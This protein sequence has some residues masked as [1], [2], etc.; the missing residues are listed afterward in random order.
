LAWI[1]SRSLIYRERMRR[2]AFSIVLAASSLACP[3]D[4]GGRTDS[5]TFSTFN[6]TGDGDGDGDGGE[7]GT[8]NTGDGDGDGDGGAM[9]G[10][11]VIE[12]GEQ[13]DLGA[14]N[15]NDGGCTTAC[16]IASCGDG[17]VYGGVEECDDGNPVETDDC[18]SN[19]L[20]ASCGDGYVHEGVEACDDGN[21]VED[22][23]CTTTCVTGI[24]GDAILQPGEQCDDGNLETSDACPACEL[25]YCGDGYTQAGVEFC[26]DGNDLDNDACLPTFCVEASCGDGFMQEGV[27]ACDDGND[28]ENDDCT[29]A[30][31]AA[32]C[33]DG[34][35]Q[36][37]EIC[38]GDQFGV[39]SCMT[40]GFNN[41]DLICTVDCEIDASD[42]NNTACP[43]GGAFVSNRCWYASSVCET[44]PV[45]CQSVGLTGADG[46]INTPWNQQVLD[47]VAAQLGLISGGVNGCCVEFG[48]I[49]NG[50]LY[51]HNFGV[52]FYNWPNCFSNNYPTLKS[53]NPP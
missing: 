5:T 38:D 47:E 31:T 16:L 26:D 36:M 46:F 51:T 24:C 45:K 8:G 44:T 20:P 13:C 4:D 25:A 14:E 19:C 28:D 15:S 22:D 2:S 1:L 17:N 18:T 32:T 49:Q 53:C 7:T 40:Q 10:N 39:E 48:W 29:T 3:S 6:T 12:D 52:Q 30:C 9:C 23:G 21:P 35:L 37:G 11:G 41:G 43:G 42:C 33:G 34:F 27:E 50:T